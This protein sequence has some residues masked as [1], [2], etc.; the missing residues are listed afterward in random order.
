MFR[1]RDKQI[2]SK[3]IVAPMAGITNDAF[4]QL[5]FEFGAGLVYTEMVS[6]KA[7]FYN[8]QK[9]LDMLKVSDEFHPVS[10]QLFG[11]EAASMVYAAKVLDQRTNCDF[12]D[13][14][15]GC[16]VSKVVK[17]GS[18]SAMMKDEDRIV[19]IV[20]KIVEAVE[21]PVTVK[22]R[23]GWDREHLNYLSLAKKL[24]G[25]GV[26]A[27]ALH[28][29]T[30]SQMY[31]GH[32]D[33]NHI[34]I[35]KENLSIPVFGNGDVKTLDDFIKMSEETNCDGVMIGRGLVGNPFLIKEIDSDLKGEDHPLNGRKDRFEYCLKHAEK[36][37]ALKGEK[38]AMSEMRG[39]APHYISG[40]Y[41]ST[42]YK[43]KMNHIKTYEDLKTIIRDYD[44]FLDEREKNSP[45]GC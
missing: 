44:L 42:T 24:E 35:L 5:C 4:R 30:R 28:A 1:I 33:W 13:I 3:I 31:E 29:R 45:S 7:I 26:S 40:L 25:A 38:M 14:N 9:T 19:E 36:L 32:A 11:S 16:P 39:L 23:L 34:R 43:E 12:I 10:L 8:N 6:D 27:I 18:G 21:K 17:T 20:K 37:I 2:D 22:M 15:M 41:D